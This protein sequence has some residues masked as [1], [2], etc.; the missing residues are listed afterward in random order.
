MPNRLKPHLAVGFFLFSVIPAVL[1]DD[2]SMTEKLASNHCAVCHTFQKGEP[3]GQGPN[4]FG[5]IG[6]T[7][8][9]VPGFAYSDGFQK[10]MA[11]AV[12]D[13]NLLDAWLLDTQTVAPGN[14]MTYFQEDPV[15]RARIIQ[16]IQSLH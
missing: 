1:A 6:R 13:R 10:A 7:A 8:G 15:K 9:S 3:N 14:A 4:L 12:W 2:L 5:L 11:G 16:Y